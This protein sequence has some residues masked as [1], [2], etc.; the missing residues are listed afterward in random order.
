MKKKPTTPITNE[1]INQV[2]NNEHK[3]ILTL[4]GQCTPIFLSC[5]RKYK[6][7]FLH[8]GIYDLM[9]EEFPTELYFACKKFNVERG[10]KFTTFL[11]Y[12]LN[13]KFL[14]LVKKKKREISQNIGHFYEEQDVEMDCRPDFFMSDIYI[15]D[16]FRQTRWSK[17]EEENQIIRMRLI[18][19]M[20]WR[21]MGKKLNRSKDYC[22]QKFKGRSKEIF[23]D[24]EEKML[25]S[26]KK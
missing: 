22:L 11:Y 20:T 16:F 10:A 21:E 12:R 15:N 2:K 8:H 18:D 4:L 3:A 14:N 24:L 13:W 1:I 17:N 5:I 7:F 26:K 19:R 6:S 9:M 23:Q 25:T